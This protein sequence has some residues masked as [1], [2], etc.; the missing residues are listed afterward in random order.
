MIRS[1]RS[2]H[3]FAWSLLVPLMCLALWAGLQNR[4]VEVTIDAA[5]HIT[6]E[7]ALP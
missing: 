2:I 4:D 6:E 7:A 3:R 5:P 1:Q